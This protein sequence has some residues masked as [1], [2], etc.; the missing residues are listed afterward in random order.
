MIAESGPLLDQDVFVKKVGAAIQVE[1]G[2]FE[3]FNAWKS[4]GLVRTVAAKDAGFTLTDDGGKAI[5]KFEGKVV[6][7]GKAGVR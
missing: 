4:P 1:T 3:R 7:Q 6:E 2:D 5:E